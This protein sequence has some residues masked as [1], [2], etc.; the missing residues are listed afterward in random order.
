MRS[1][2]GLLVAGVV[3]AGIA[4]GLARVPRVL[5]HVELFRVSDFQVVGS[6]YL[7]DE[8]AVAA[9]A[10]PSG[11]SVWDDLEPFAARLRAHPLVQDARVE[12]KLPGTLVLRVVE[13]EPVVLMPTP[14]LVPL[15]AGGRMLPIDPALHRLD[16]PL[17]QP[18]RASGTTELTPAEIR[19]LVEEMARLTVA[20]PDF[21]MRVSEAAYDPRGDVRVRLA[22]PEIEVYFRAPLSPQRLLEGLAALGDATERRPPDRISA[23]DLRYA[24]QVV[25]RFSPNGR[26]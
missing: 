10:V 23:I 16:L 21:M 4:L 8:E 20:E 11:A 1:V 24:D 6:R 12:R 26:N 5:A 15:D 25:V 3:I 2:L 13:R 14:A 17:I 19:A 18:F 9:V 7:S 22:D